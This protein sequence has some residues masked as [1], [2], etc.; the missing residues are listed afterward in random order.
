MKA[1][2]YSASLALALC[3]AATS[4]GNG[5][6]G[7]ADDTLV[8]KQTSDSL[9]AAYG[10]MAGSYINGELVYYA[11]ATG[12]G[13]DRREFVKGIQAVVGSEHPDAYIAG[14]NTGLRVYQDLVGMK[15]QGV[16]V[17]RAKLIEA[18]RKAILA[19]SLT[20]VEREKAQTEYQV[21]LA[22]VQAMAQQREEKKLAEAPKA[23]QN[24][25][26][27]QAF[28]DNLRK[29]TPGVKTTESGLTYVVETPGEGVPVK[30]GDR[31]TL[32]YVG[33]HLNGEVFDQGE[34]ATLVPGNGLI[35][36]F[37][38]ALTLMYKGGKATFYIPGELAYGA[39]GVE[40]AG[41]GPMETLVFEIEV[42][43]VNADKAA[44]QE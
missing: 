33:K 13:Y 35:A 5:E 22:R 4:C 21:L 29:T 23:V 19:D 14:M 36:G 18:L 44:E 42:L 17:N 40:Q 32:N 7:G 39:K 24:Q 1:K 9:C 37:S 28:I 2:I 26:A 6:K 30:N 25:K 8:S 43:D 27:S 38:E 3:M 11:D 31:V 10:A 20:D 16:Q 12:T 34:G 41:I 15:N